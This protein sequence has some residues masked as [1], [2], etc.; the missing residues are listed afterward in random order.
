M[1]AHSENFFGGKFK[2]MALSRLIWTACLSRHNT[3]EN[4]PIRVGKSSILISWQHSRRQYW[5]SFNSRDLMILAQPLKLI[6]AE[7]I[8]QK[9]ASLLQFS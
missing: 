2:A 9:R 6:V 5:I 1:K 7:P 3:K 8:C 4:V